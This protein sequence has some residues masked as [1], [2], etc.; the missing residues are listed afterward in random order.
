[1]KCCIC[2]AVKNCEP[3]LDRIFANIESI[4]S[5]FDDY[6][7]IFYYG[8]S[9]DATLQKLK[10]YQQQNSK[11][12]F[13]VDNNEQSKCRTHRIAKARNG[14]LQQI[15]TNYA[16]YEMFIMMDCDDVCSNTVNTDILKKYLYRDDWDSLS[17]NKSPYYDIWALS[18]KPY[19][20]S[21]IHYKGDVYSNM[22]TY[23]INSLNKVPKNGLLR[24]A[25]AFNGFAIYRTNKFLNCIYD[26]KPRF[27]L[28]PKNA[29]KLCSHINGN[30]II[31]TDLGSEKSLLEDCEHRSFHLEAIKKNNARIRISPEIIF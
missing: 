12:Q 11:L 28:M 18:I 15:R 19:Y 30:I 1:M 3:W 26:G 8:K 25:S 5:L 13:F 9:S 14:C 31:N 20:F 29:L 6:V 23:I 17:F 7:I 22:K 4:G 10:D 2:A 16:N 27:D 24:C 21:F